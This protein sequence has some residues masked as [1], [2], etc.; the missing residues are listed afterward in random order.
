M[1]RRVFI[2]TN[3]LVYCF[4]SDEPSKRERALAVLE[5]RDLD[6]DLILSTQVLQEFY[7][8]VVRKLARPLDEAD[9]A[10]AVR[11]LARLPVVQIDASMVLGAIELS[12]E[13]QLSLWD[14]LILRAAHTADCTAVLTEDLQHGFH[15]AGVTVQNP[16]LA[17]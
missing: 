12:R 13:H 3:V 8:A 11:E 5:G 15:W 6:D 16:F 14:A 7:V 4:D 17:C 2:D 1:S 9:A 10:Q